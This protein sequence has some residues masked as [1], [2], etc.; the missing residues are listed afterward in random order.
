MIAAALFFSF[1]SI[2]KHFLFIIES[3]KMSEDAVESVP[4]EDTTL[5]KPENIKTEDEIIFPMP[6]MTVSQSNTEVVNET[7]IVAST[8]QVKQELDKKPAVSKK[9]ATSEGT[10]GSSPKKRVIEREAS[11]E[12]EEE[13]TSNKKELQEEERSRMQ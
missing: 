10:S 5:I 6:S 8:S 7:T 13:F 12:G 3:K 11:K 2:Y 4:T 9:R 1:L